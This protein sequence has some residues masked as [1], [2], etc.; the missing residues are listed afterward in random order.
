MSTF[1]RA[2]GQ[3]D[4]ITTSGTGAFNF[5]AGAGTLLGGLLITT[6]GVA[7]GVTMAVMDTVSGTAASGLWLI[8]S[9]A[10][11]VLANLPWLTISGVPIQD[12]AQYIPI[13]AIAYSGWAV[14]LSGSGA[15]ANLAVQV[16]AF[17]NS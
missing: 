5:G 7:S 10:R 9:G 6:S 2:E 11:V 15:G 17:F 4:F 12:R 1:S 13:N 3:F 16:T 8:A 14:F